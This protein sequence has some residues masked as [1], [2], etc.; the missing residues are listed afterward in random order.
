[1]RLFGDLY[2]VRWTGPDSAEVIGHRS[3]EDMPDGVIYKPCGNRRASVCPFCSKRYQRDAYQIV[4]A[5]LVG[6]KGVPEE[7]ATH[8]AVFPTFTAP[9]FGPVHTRYVKRHTCGKRSGCDCR[10]EPCRPRRELVFC[11]HG[12]RMVCFARHA[13][14]DAQLGAPFCPDC[15]DYDGQAAWHAHTRELWRRT[16][17]ALRRYLA[18]TARRRGIHPDRIN[19]S[20]GKAAEMQRR[21]AVHFHAIMRLDGR[22]PANNGVVLPLPRGPYGQSLDAPDLG[23]AVDHAAK[24]VSFRTEAHPDR[25]NGWLI[26]WGKEVLTKVVTVA[27]EGEVTDAMVAAYL[28]KYATKSTEITGHVA[29][30]IN[31]ANLDVYADPGGSHPQRLVAACWRLGRDKHWWR[32]R[33]WAH[34]LGFGGHFLTK[35]R[36]YSVTFGMLRQARITYRRTPNAGPDTAGQTPQPD[37]V[38]QVNLLRYVGSGWHTAADALLANASAALARE[39]QQAARQYIT[40]RAA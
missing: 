39:H 3:T 9:S 16:I 36:T 38:V 35:S 21:G 31:D 20:L 7:V 14:T 24:T 8:P 15:Y 37:P 10:P 13:D 33:R 5:G 12:R 22:D 6:G 40:T 25:P 17:I 2:T 30:R 27:A 26:R 32:L 23:D 19:A 4:R 18:R 29:P 34:M 1:V 28:A 11:P